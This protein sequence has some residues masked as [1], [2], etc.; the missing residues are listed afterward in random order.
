MIYEHDIKDGDLQTWSNMVIWAR[1][2]TMFH[3]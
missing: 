2:L 1:K 3:Q